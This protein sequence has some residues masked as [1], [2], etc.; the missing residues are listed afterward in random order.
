VTNEPVSGGLVSRR[1]AGR[2]RELALAAAFAGLAGGLVGD[3]DVPELLHAL[4]GHCVDLLDATSCG[5]LLTD[6]RGRLR[7]LAAHPESAELLE[8]VQLQ[9]DEGPCVDCVRTGEAVSSADLAAE[10]GRWPRWAPQAVAAGIRSVYATPLRTR[11]T[12]IG[13]LNLFGGEVRGTSERDLLIIRALA[14]VA[15]LTVLQQRHTFEAGQLNAQ[16]QTALTSRIG[17]DQ[18][19]G[20]IAHAWS[21]DMD[22]AFQVLR[23]NSRVTNTKLSVIAD[24]LVHARIAPTDLLP[25]PYTTS[26]GA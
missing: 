23:H 6:D 11:D 2:D 8:V 18:A 14:D 9:N 24:A 5:I 10:V 16:L 13:T 1:V 17:I 20:I 19:K 4:A 3:V 15:T 21:V 25:L 12:V 26:T 7:L 22:T